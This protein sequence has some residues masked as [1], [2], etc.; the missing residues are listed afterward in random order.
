MGLAPL[1]VERVFETIRAI[2]EQG[3]T[4][5]LVEQNAVMAL[6]IADEAYVM[7]SGRIVLRGRG[8]DLLDDEQV[9]R[10]YLG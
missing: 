6:D 8:K 3:V 10:A 1:M 4:I 9:Q 5:L 2:N 7:E